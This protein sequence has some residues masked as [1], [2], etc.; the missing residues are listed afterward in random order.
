MHNPS[1]KSLS[2]DLFPDLFLMLEL[3]WDSLVGTV[4]IFVSV[5]G[6]FPHLLP[7]LQNYM[8][9]QRIR[10]PFRPLLFVMYLFNWT[11]VI[12]LLA[13]LGESCQKRKGICPWLFMRR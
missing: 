7:V 10:V 3:F 12:M 2:Q 13:A 9:D 8:Q 6:G 5:R 4:N 11:D 1:Q